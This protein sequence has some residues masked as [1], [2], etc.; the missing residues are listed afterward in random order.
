M[1][2]SKY[3]PLKAFGFLF[4]ALA[5]AALTWVHRA[6]A[7]EA[8]CSQL[9]DQEMKAAALGTFDHPKLDKK[10]EK[11]TRNP[12]VE[13]F[14]LNGRRQA[15]VEKF[16][17]TLPQASLPDPKKMTKDAY[18]YAFQKVQDQFDA[19][20]EGKGFLAQSRRLDAELDRMPRWESDLMGELAY[21][22]SQPAFDEIVV[23]S[24]VKGSPQKVTA[25]LKGGKIRAFISNLGLGEEASVRKV[26][27]NPD[28][29]VASYSAYLPRFLDGKGRMWFSVSDKVCQWVPR[30]RELGSR[31]PDHTIEPP[32]G[33]HRSN[34]V[35]E[36]SEISQLTGWVPPRAS[37]YQLLFK[38]P[39]SPFFAQCEALRGQLAPESADR[40]G[41]P[42]EV[43]G[44][45]K[46][47]QATPPR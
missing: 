26:V 32:P 18:H 21:E 29:K 27:V 11:T 9:I 38:S 6:D 43:G 39:K 47:G 17:E 14:I 20:E 31:L 28:C 2:C 36:V 15:A 41:H 5:F 40:A 46:P 1:S 10:P 45:E 35:P 42:A 33:P 19:T 44:G 3:Y 13:S 23:I 30:I 34:T 22:D 24:G 16:K 4:A 8:K 37:D 12:F 25:F 7:S